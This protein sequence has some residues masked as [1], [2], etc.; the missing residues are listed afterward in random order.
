E[1]REGHEISIDKMKEV[2]KLLD[3]SPSGMKGLAR[4]LMAF[5]I[6]TIVAFALVGVFVSKNPDASDLSKTIIASLLS[7]LATIIGFYF[8]SRTSE[9]AQEAAAAAA[10]DQKAAGSQPDQGPR[11]RGPR[12]NDGEPG[13]DNNDAEPGHEGA[14]MRNG[15]HQGQAGG[16]QR[17]QPSQSD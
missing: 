9:W 13:S 2:M 12:R 6:I 3:R 11:S 7:V 8:G 4:A 16:K 5:S 1:E 10:A 14:G 15:H 17:T